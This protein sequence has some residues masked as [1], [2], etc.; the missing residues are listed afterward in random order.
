M[1]L[2]LLSLVSTEESGAAVAGSRQRLAAALEA[3][4]HFIVPAE[5]PAAHGVAASDEAARFARADCDGMVLCFFSGDGAAVAL[6]T[7]PGMVVQAALHAACP[8]LLASDD[9]P[10]LLAASGALQEI[11]VSAGRTFGAPDEPGTVARVQAW[12]ALHDPAERRRGQDAAGKLFGSR[13]AVLGD[14]P[15][16]GGDVFAVD[17]ARWLTQFGVHVQHAGASALAGRSISDFCAGER[18]TF[19]SLGLAADGTVLALPEAGVL[20]LPAACGANGALTSQLL[21]VTTGDAAAVFTIALTGRDAASPDRLCVRAVSGETALTVPLTFARI[22]RRLGRFTC[23]IG[24]GSVGEDGTALLRPDCGGEALL[25]VADSPFLH[26]A[27]G[28]LRA[29][30]KAACESLDVE[31]ILLA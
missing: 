2:G 18:I 31:P 23:L 13:Y 28:D 12:A 19:C 11:G 26:A 25:L 4:G 6:E 27:P 8:L 9:L 14:P 7:V 24:T 20:V 17:A 1:K 21:A 30:L 29:A 10:V 15:P 5:K 3:A 16:G 22:T